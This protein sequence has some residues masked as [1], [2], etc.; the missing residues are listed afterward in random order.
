MAFVTREL[1]KK[2]EQT[3]IEKLNE[4]EKL[5]EYTDGQTNRY[6][7]IYCWTRHPTRNDFIDKINEL[8]DVVNELRE[9]LNKRKD[10]A[11]VH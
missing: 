8:V 3:K 5:E 2:M 6:G 11:E 9:E 1:R 7:E 4:I 10:N